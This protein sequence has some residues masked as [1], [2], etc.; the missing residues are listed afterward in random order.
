MSDVL[1][2]AVKY[3]NRLRAELARLEEFLRLAEDLSRESDPEIR[4]A[5]AR[6]GLG[7]DRPEAVR[8]PEQPGAAGHRPGPAGTA[9][10]A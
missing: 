6:S 7:S 8:K 5:T 9:A 3:R 1:Q 10:T 4:L 2:T